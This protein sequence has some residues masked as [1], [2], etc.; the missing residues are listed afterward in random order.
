[1]LFVFLMCFYIQTSAKEVIGWIEEVQITPENLPIRAKIDTGAR[2]SSLH[3][4]CRTY[5]KENG[6]TW[7]KLTVTNY[8]GK[9]LQ[10]EKPVIR[11]AIIKRHGEKRQVR[12]VIKMQ[13]CLGNVRKE[14]EVNLFN[15][16]GLN[17]KL[18]IGRS[19]LRGSFLIDTEKKY[20]TK[21]HCK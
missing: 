16:E 19:F 6:K 5:R 4:D 14:V 21:P 17:Y 15:R 2:H 13:I 7:V 8:Q 20:L 18:L 12:D 3:C 1:M 9:S 11:Q 10:L